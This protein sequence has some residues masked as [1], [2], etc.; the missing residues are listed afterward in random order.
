MF[1]DDD[2]RTAPQ[3]DERFWRFRYSLRRWRWCKYCGH[4]TPQFLF[5]EG[6]IGKDF[7][8]CTLRCCWECGSGVGEYD[9]KVGDRYLI[10]RH[11]CDGGEF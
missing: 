2:K 8:G 3:V 4:D 9:H 5:I 7:P 11:C 1:Y 6:M 10:M